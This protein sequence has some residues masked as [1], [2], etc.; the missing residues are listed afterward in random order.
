MRSTGSFVSRRKGLAK[1]GHGLFT[2]SY[3]PPY[4]FFADA[5]KDM[6]YDGAGCIPQPGHI[7]SRDEGRG[8][9]DIRILNELLDSTTEVNQVLIRMGEGTLPP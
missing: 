1:K 2:V 4:L 3:F 5:V 9:Y 7:F 8:A 6:P